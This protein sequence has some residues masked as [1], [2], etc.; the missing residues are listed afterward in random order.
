MAILHG[1]GTLLVGALVI[2]ACLLVV[3]VV[4]AAVMWLGKRLYAR[5][6]K[7]W[8]VI[9]ALANA[10]AVLYVVVWAGFVAY[11]VGQVVLAWLAP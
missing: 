11:G 5:W 3:G 8:A 7:P 4:L 10:A 2:V 6:P 9:L 1:V